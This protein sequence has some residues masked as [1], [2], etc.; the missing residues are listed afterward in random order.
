MFGK[1]QPNLESFLFDFS[2]DLYGAELSVAF[3]AYLRP[4]LKF[5]GLQELRDQMAKDCAQART[6]LEPL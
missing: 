6:I 3:V 5:D 1:N 4:E 2:G